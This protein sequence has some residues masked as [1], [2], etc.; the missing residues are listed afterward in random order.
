MFWLTDSL[1]PVERY[2]KLVA[3]AGGVSWLYKG[4]KMSSRDKAIHNHFMLLLAAVRA[5]DCQRMASH[6]AALLR[7]GVAVRIATDEEL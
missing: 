1:L 2:T 7:N 4:K 6:Q 5:E 3:F